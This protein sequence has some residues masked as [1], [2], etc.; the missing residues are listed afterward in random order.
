MAD[1]IRVSV[2]LALRDRQP[3]VE[4]RVGAGTTVAE[5]LRLARDAR[6]WPGWP[7]E[8]RLGIFGKLVAEERPVVDGDRIEVL[9]PLRDDPKEVRR[10]RAA[11]ARGPRSARGR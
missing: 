7:A 8:Y 2:V 11:A 9:R 5:A 6:D 10:Q 3:A 4:L 1:G